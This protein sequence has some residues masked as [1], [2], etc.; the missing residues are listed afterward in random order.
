M[1]GEPVEAR[2]RHGVVGFE[3]GSELVH[4][5]GLLHNEPFQIPREQFE[6]VHGWAVRLQHGQ[7]RPSGTSR[8]CQEQR[9]ARIRLGP[10]GWAPAPQRRWV[11]GTDRTPASSRAL[12][13]RPCVVST[14]HAT[15]SPVG[16]PAAGR[17]PIPPVHRAVRDSQSADDL[18]GAVTT[19]AS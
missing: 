10:R 12:I 15:C 8:A 18:P 1:A 17:P 4:Q 11:D 3:A 5:P 14:T 16:R 7:V 6:F 2:E 19:T 13:R 9:V